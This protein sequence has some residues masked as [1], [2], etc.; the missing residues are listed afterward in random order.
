MKRLES[1]EG[2]PSGRTEI[3][4]MEGAHAQTPFLRARGSG[5]EWG[6]GGSDHRG[7]GVQGG[8]SSCVGCEGLRGVQARRQKRFLLVKLRRTALGEPEG[9]P[10]LRWGAPLSPGRKEPRLARG[11]CRER[12]PLTQVRHTVEARV[13]ADLSHFVGA[14]QEEVDHAVRDHAAREADELV[15]KA[16][17]LPEAVPAARRARLHAQQLPVGGGEARDLAHSAPDLR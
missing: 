9:S 12:A 6:R 4:G 13:E 16:T 2:Q 8:P 17:P 11:P 10:E 15:V 3:W 1:A 5:W 7:R 14:C